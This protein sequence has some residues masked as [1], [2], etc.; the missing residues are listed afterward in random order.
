MTSCFKFEIIVRA[1]AP[2]GLQ[3]FFFYNIVYAC[4]A[5]LIIPSLGVIDLYIR[6]TLLFHWACKKMKSWIRG[7][8]FNK[9]PSLLSIYYLSSF[10]S[11]S[12]PTLLT[13][14]FIYFPVDHFMF[15]LDCMAARGF[16]Y[17]LCRPLVFSVG[18]ISISFA[19]VFQ[20]YSLFSERV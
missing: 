9:A 1:V 5:I 4:K 2:S 8:I 16:L 12:N 13:L 17:S 7:C 3:T 10:L 20:G 11:F 14:L 19:L 18:D 6:W 15:K